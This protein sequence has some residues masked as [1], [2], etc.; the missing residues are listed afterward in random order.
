MVSGLLEQYLAFLSV[1]KGLRAKSLEAYETDIREF[2]AFIEE[3]SDKP[4]EETT[5]GQIALFMVHLHEKGLAP[6]SMARKASAIKGYFRFLLREHIISDDPTKFIITPKLG[7]PLPKVLSLN[8]V[9]RILAQPDSTTPLG[10]R[11]RAILE[12]LYGAGLRES[13]L[14]DLQLGNINF[15]AEFINVCGKGGRER[16]VPIGEY[17]LAAVKEYMNYGRS[18]LLRDVSERTM[19][20]NPYGRKMS[21]MGIWKLVKKY[22]LMAGISKQVSPHVFRHSCATHM[23]EG[24]AGILAVQEMLG[25]VDISTTQ[26]YTHLTSRDLKKIHM[27]CHPRGT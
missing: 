2:T 19:F 9:E 3:R 26:I 8:E 27:N 1:E 10:I 22:S 5:A 21:R 4:G 6:R 11:D 16:V 23:L 14:I 18:K 12:V 13:E 17:A 20:L 15:D 7:R 25:H 24:G